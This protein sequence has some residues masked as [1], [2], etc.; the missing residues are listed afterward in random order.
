MD[1]NTSPSK[2]S[3]KASR[4]SWA[5]GKHGD[6]TGRARGARCAFFARMPT[7]SMS[8]RTTPGAVV[9]HDAQGPRVPG[10]RLLARQAPFEHM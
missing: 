6:A 2:H 5:S 10:A 9:Y 4:T 1:A 3:H 8:S 7:T